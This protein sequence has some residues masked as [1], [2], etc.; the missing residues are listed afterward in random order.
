MC[1]HCEEGTH[2]GLSQTISLAQPTTIRVADYVYKVIEV[3]SCP[4]P[5]MSAKIF[6]VDSA[7]VGWFAEM[8]NRP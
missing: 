8:T 1:L 6:E 7:A 4:A 3:G 5:P 2:P